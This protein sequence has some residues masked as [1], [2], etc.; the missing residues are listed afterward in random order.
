VAVTISV[1]GRGEADI[2]STDGTRVV[3]DCASSAPPGASLSC[4]LDGAPPFRIKVSSCKWSSD[5]GEKAFRIEGRFVDLTREQRA[6][7]GGALQRG[8]S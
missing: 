8:S 1:E 3:L 5:P 7:L 4:M 2:V 6:R